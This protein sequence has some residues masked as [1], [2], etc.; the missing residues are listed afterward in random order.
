MQ[1]TSSVFQ[2]NGPIPQKYSCEGE[3]IH[4]PLSFEDVAENTKSLVLIV[5]DPDAPMGTF[6]HWVLFN[7]SPTTT[8]IP[9][10]KVPEG[11][12]QG[13]NT[14]GRGDYVAP[15]PP[16]GTHRYRF[17]LWALSEKLRINSGAT[18]EEVEREA[19]KFIIE[20]AVL[21]GTYEKSSS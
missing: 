10:G 14:S 15:C 4:P 13:K 1:L 8:E 11:A 12:V 16:S 17:F 18:R 6:V 9:E 3:G 19:E 7:I 2:N 21:L 5:D 20:R